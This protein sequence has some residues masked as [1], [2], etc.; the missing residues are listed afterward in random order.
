MI[1]EGVIIEVTWNLRVFILQHIAQMGIW[2]LELVFIQVEDIVILGIRVHE[3]LAII[4]ELV[5]TTYLR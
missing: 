3:V 5:G 1:I 2:F 4:L